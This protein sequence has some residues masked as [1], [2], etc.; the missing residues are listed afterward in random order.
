MLA[1]LA[2]SPAAAQTLTVLYSFT[3]GTD[4]NTPS[5]GLVGD[6]AGNLYGTTRFGGDLTCGY[7]SGCGTVFKL[8]AT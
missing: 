2:F 8:D 4:G 6:A 7:P 3:G 1:L 5:E